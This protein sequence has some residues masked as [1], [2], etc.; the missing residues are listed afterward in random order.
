MSFY[1]S[2]NAIKNAQTDL[3]VVSN[4]IANSET[5]G[6]KRSTVTF[7][8]VVAGTAFTNPRLIEGIGAKV[9]AISQNFKQG[10][11]DATGSSLD[12]AI[13]GDG[14]FTIKSPTT[15]QT[16]YTRNGAFQMDSGG[17]VTDS[18]GNRVQMYP[19]DAAGA[20]TST[21]MADGLVPIT[22][23]AGSEFAG[24]TVSE[25]GNV[26][27]SYADGTNTVI[28]K[29]TLATFL[30]PQGLRQQGS[31]DWTATNIS[32]LANYG[33]P[34]NGQYGKLMSGYLE[35]S[36]VEVSDELVGLIVAQ[37]AYQANAK[38]IDTAT[39]AT[40]AILNLRS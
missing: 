12:M 19:T 1:T 37:R 35:R 34:T 40:Q 20:V 23:P 32:G 4:N 21:T 11:M 25:N 29:V 18:Q 10:A 26:A 9:D 28:G 6:F 15:G 3:N 22:N 17:Y 38:A 5:N 33:E 16:M 8:D 2:L 36:N 24:L 14:F 13:S 31:S 30:N 7:A 39:Q 27:A